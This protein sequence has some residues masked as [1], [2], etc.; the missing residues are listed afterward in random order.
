MSFAPVRTNGELSHWVGAIRDITEEKERREELEKQNE[1]L[2]RYQ[3]VIE[4]ATDLIT[5]KSTSGEYLLINRAARNKSPLYSELADHQEDRIFFENDPDPKLWSAL[6]QIE[7]R[8][9]EVIESQRVEQTEET[10]PTKG[11]EA[12]Y[13]T[14]RIPFQLE[15]GKEGIINISKDI[16]ELKDKERQLQETNER[17]T[18]VAENIEEAFYLTSPDLEEVFY[19][20]RAAG[21]LYG[22]TPAELEEN[23]FCWL[24][25]IRDEYVAQFEQ[26]MLSG[27]GRIEEFKMQEFEL[28]HPS[29]GHRWLVAKVYPISDE[30][31]EVYRLV[32]VTQDITERREAEKRLRRSEKMSALGRM[33]G[34]VAHDFNNFISVILGYADLIED[35]I[36][37]D[38]V[39]E[40]LTE[41]R[42][43]G[44]SAQ[45]LVE[46]LLNFAR[47]GEGKVKS[48]DAMEL[49]EQKRGLLDQA[50][51]EDI[52]FE[53]GGRC[54]ADC[55]VMAD[56]SKM[57]QVWLNLAVNAADA[58]PEGG[59]L[60]VDVA[61]GEPK[62]GKGSFQEDYI[63]YSFSDTGG[64]IPEDIQDKIFEPLFSTKGDDGTGLG[65]A[66]CQGIVRDLGGDIVLRESTE[67]GT[68]F[69]VYLPIAT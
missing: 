22:V 69:D 26:D 37:S 13:L 30:T 21:R 9:R 29:R 4:N 35:Q 27:A 41:L 1:T 34:G 60:T 20:N 36:Q 17:L 62:E 38:E 14:T 23:P 33:A 66:T 32:T 31:G 2:K 46:D 51:G 7:R 50:V 45:Q 67:D 64:G 44:E 25:N 8:D 42:E 65:L 24:K 15:E 10:L 39:L 48:I 49:I 28:D 68:T 47:S 59:Q 57:S 58:M 61:R 56:P 5:I 11:G 16:T 52:A 63:R 40:D 53:F 19:A 18:Q 54:D 12:T 43:A 6:D 3:L 55:R